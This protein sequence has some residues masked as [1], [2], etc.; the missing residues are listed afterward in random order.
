VPAAAVAGLHKHA[1]GP[2]GRWISTVT[3][4]IVVV[5]AAGGVFLLLHHHAS[6][7]P[8][9]RKA[10]SSRT[11]PPS[12]QTTPAVAGS[13]LVSVGAAAANSP[14][15]PAVV[16]FLSR[17]FTAINQHDYAAYQRLFSP[18]LR[19]GLSA[20]DF[21]SG[22]GSSLD[23]RAKLHSITPAGVGQIAVSVTFIS[24]QQVT[25]SQTQSGCT[26]WN[27]TLYLAAQG[28]GFV[29]VSPPAGYTPTFRDCS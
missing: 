16:S 9:G 14:Q 8:A 6:A 10:A 17:Y 25:T 15:E 26:A 18:A 27:I 4:A 7:P 13:Q 12:S 2:S 19:T 28:Q 21:Q 20:A 5:I 29:I 22:Y 3:A 1:R 11:T 23:S 24:H